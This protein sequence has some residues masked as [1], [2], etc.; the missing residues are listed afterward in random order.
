MAQ[1]KSSA[2]KHIGKIEAGI[3]KAELFIEQ[4]SKNIIYAIAAVILVVATFFAYK[5]WY[6]E[7]LE[8][9]AQAQ[10]FQAQQLFESDSMRLAIEGD[11]SFLGFVEVADRYSRTDAGN[12]ARFYAGIAYLH[13]G[14]YEEAIEILKKYKG[15]GLFG[16]ALAFGNIGDAYTELG[17]WDEALK[18]YK[19][20]ANACDNAM[21]TPRFLAKAALVAQQLEKYT[22]AME[23]YEQIQHQYYNSTEANDAEKYIARLK[24]LISN[25]Q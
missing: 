11:G 2:P 21:T 10:L 12:A 9:E 13:T 15:S 24:I 4:H 18:Y 7:P 17:E 23:F 20:A 5:K 14:Q 6:K 3:G 22:D 16:K 25:Q 19:K 8:E 1:Q